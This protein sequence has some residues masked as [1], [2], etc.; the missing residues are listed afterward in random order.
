MRS[1]EPDSRLQSPPTRRHKK[2]SLDIKPYLGMFATT[3]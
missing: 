1:A 2:L 3:V